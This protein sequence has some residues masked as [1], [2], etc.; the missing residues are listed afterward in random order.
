MKRILFRIIMLLCCVLFAE[1]TSAAVDDVT[2]M[3]RKQAY[4]DLINKLSFDLGGP[5]LSTADIAG[6]LEWKLLEA[7]DLTSEVESMANLKYIEYK[8]EFRFKDELLYYCY[9]V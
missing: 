5:Y 2:E 7:R 6:N 9:C 1:V 4:E 8:L 3:T